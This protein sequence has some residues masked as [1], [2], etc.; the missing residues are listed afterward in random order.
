MSVEKR[1]LW[2][3][4]V[5]RVPEHFSWVDHRLVREGYMRQCQ[6]CVPPERGVVTGVV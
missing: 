5:R 4:R 6:A 3:E 2:A 1:V